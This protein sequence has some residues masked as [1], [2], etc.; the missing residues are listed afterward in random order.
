MLSAVLTDGTRLSELGY[1]MESHNS[2]RYRHR[3]PSTF[4]KRLSGV[5]C[6]NESQEQS[7]CHICFCYPDQV[8]I[9]SSYFPFLALTAFAH[10]SII[11]I[12]IVRQTFLN[13]AYH[14]PP[15]LFSISDTIISTE[16]LLHCSIMAATIPCLKPFVMAFNTGWGQGTKRGAGSYYD[17][18]GTSESH[19]A[20]GA[21]QPSVDEADIGPAAE[22]SA[23]NG[24][25]W[26]IRQTREW[27]VHSEFI[28]MQAIRR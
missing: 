17:R 19:S 9:L 6:S 28:P 27:T 25:P 2:L 12:A 15:I 5:E 23:S 24:A 1:P 14:H 26:R 7:G 4:L 21:Q 18:S 22:G 16:V 11:I 13:K 20:S 10:R 8:C 3:S